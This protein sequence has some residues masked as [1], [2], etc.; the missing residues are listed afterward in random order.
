MKNS[1]I[2][3]LKLILNHFMKG[4]GVLSKLGI[5][6]VLLLITGVFLFG[7]SLFNN[8]KSFEN[9]KLE[10]T[11]PADWTPTNFTAINTSYSVQLY[12][13]DT[14]IIF[15]VT[16]KTEVTKINMYTSDDPDEIILRKLV[17]KKYPE[18]AKSCERD[19]LYKKRHSLVTLKYKSIVDGKT[20][21]RIFFLDGI[22]F[23]IIEGK[24]SKDDGVLEDKLDKIAL[25]LD[26]KAL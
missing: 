6:I 18:I 15:P 5:L 10:F 1:K 21:I 9:D 25:S 14:N 4:R 12:G 16:I 22:H 17:G 24:T 20:E 7:S 3:I 26:D 2:L 13:N 8:N 19:D 11:Y 23:C